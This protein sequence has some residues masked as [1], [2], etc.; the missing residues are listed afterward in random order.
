M[1]SSIKVL[2]IIIYHYIF[3]G[4]FNYS[5]IQ[6]FCKLSGTRV[7]EGKNI[8]VPFFLHIDSFQFYYVFLA[9]QE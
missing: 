9:A 7:L 4:T 1:Q 8:I 3:L 5:D 6:F 2:Y